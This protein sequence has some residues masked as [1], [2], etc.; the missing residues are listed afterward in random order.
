MVWLPAVVLIY[1][2]YTAIGPISQII[3]TQ[4]LTYWDLYSWF[5][6]FGG[7]LPLAVLPFYNGEKGNMPKWIWYVFYP[8]QFI[9][10]VAIIAFV[11]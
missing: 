1:L 5:T 4:M 9:L 8:I 11:F 10:I 6:G 2:A 3:Q 7:F